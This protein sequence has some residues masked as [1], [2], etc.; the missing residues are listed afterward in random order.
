MCVQN[1]LLVR[2]SK[3]QLLHFAR[4]VASS[5]SVLAFQ[6]ICP[7]PSGVKATPYSQLTEWGTEGEP[8]NVSFLIACGHDFV[9]CFDTN[10][11]AVGV[12][13]ALKRQFPDL[14][15]GWMTREAT[16]NW[17]NLFALIDT[18]LEE[19]RRADR[20]FLQRL[21]DFLFSFKHA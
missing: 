14:H 18:R 13:M 6:K 9:Y 8:E 12:A 17:S 2:G 16:D 20:S 1:R 19:M 3:V 7:L 11:T 15:F 5:D 4:S 10:R 21:K